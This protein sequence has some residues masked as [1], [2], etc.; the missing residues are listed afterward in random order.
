MSAISV[1]MSPSCRL[2]MD[3]PITTARLVDV[4]K[5]T[6]LLACGGVNGTESGHIT[7]HKA[8]ALDHTKFKSMRSWGDTHLNLN[9]QTKKPLK[10]LQVGFGQHVHKVAVVVDLSVVRQ[11][12]AVDV[13]RWYIKTPCT[14]RFN[15]LTE[16]N[17]AMPV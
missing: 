2:Q 3:G 11:W 13:Q 8:V 5:L 14:Q 10:Y 17:L 12:Q 7:P 9:Q 6:S 1:I 15:E 4:I 16:I